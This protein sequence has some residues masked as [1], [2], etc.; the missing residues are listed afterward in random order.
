VL[1]NGRYKNIEHKAMV[2]A[3]HNRI[4]AAMDLLP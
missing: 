1:T 4:F 3:R 2:N